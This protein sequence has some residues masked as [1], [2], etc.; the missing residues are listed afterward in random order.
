[1]KTLVKDVLGESKAEE[2]IKEKERIKRAMEKEAS[3]N[4]IA[5]SQ[6]MLGR[7][8]KYAHEKHKSKD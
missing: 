5:H 4:F 1:M 8:V 6:N 7:I 2:R 3:C